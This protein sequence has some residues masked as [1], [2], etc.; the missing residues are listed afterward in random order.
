MHIRLV[1]PMISALFLAFNASAV[2][3]TQTFKS[4][5]SVNVWDYYGNVSAL[6]WNYLGYAPFDSSL[7]KLTS[8]S[9]VETI[10]GTR[11]NS[12]DA[13]DI[14]EAFFTGWD[15][16][17]YQF[18]SSYTIAPGS[19]DFSQTFTHTYSDEPAL[20]RLTNYQYYTGVQS[21]GKGTGGAWYYFESG[22]KTG[23][24]SISSE[25]VLTYVYEA[26]SPVSEP[27]SY[28]FMFMGLSVIGA[29]KLRARST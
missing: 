18:Y 3:I 21:S 14:R 4:N 12:A 22:T 19:N 29:V 16:S 28:A 1:V 10:S 15:P 24:H 13:L 5:W 23:A 27:A 25:T 9:V 7:G 11:E 17:R 26:A 2:T 6:R 8:I 20:T